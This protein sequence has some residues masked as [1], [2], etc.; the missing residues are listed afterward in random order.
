LDTTKATSLLQLAL[1][2]LEAFGGFVQ[3]DVPGKVDIEVPGTAVGDRTKLT[4]ARIVCNVSACDLSIVELTDSRVA[5]LWPAHGE[6]HASLDAL[7][8]LCRFALRTGNTE[9]VSPLNNHE[10][11]RLEFACE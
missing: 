3:K 10:Y 7:R 2:P 5:V 11:T 1:Y 9:V 8:T 6:L 4:A